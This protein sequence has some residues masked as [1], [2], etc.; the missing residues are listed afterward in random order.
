ME[1][2][3]KMP[4]RGIKFSGLAKWIRVM[5][6]TTFLLFFAV[7]QILA[8][9][10]YSQTKL[11][12]IN[13][14]NATV[15]DIL[16]EIEENSEFY[17]LYSNK[18]INADRKLSVSVEE[19]KMEEVL[20]LIF[21]GEDVAYSIMDRQVIIYPE[22]MLPET[23]IFYQQQ[24]KR[25]S[26]TVTS[27][28]GQP[29]PG[30]TI[31]IEGTTQ[32]TVTNSEGEYLLTNVPED[33][34]LVFSFVGMK[35]QK[36]AVRNQTNIN[37]TLEED[38]IGIEEVVAIGYGT[39]RKRDLTGSVQRADIESFVEQP[40]LSIMQSLHGSVP[41]LNVG[42][43]NQAGQ[44]PVISI[45]GLTTLSGE[46]APLIVLDGVIFRGNI[47]DINPNDIK[48][49]DVLKDASSTAVYGS[50][51]ANGVIIITTS[52]AGGK[53]GKPV[54][55]LSSKYSFQRPYKAFEY[56]DTDYF[57]KK[58]ER[59]DFYSSR[60]EASGYLEPN[61][62]Y[63][64]TSRFNTA[65]E[66]WAYENN[67]IT[68]WYDLVTRDNI[69]TQ[70]HNVS[71]SNTTKVNNYYISLGY[72]DQVGYMLNEDYS[73]INARINVDNNITDWLTVGI[74]S[75]MSQSDYSGAEISPRFRYEHNPYMTVYDE[76]GDY[77]TAP[78][79]Q[80]INP[81]LTA[82]AD[83]LDKRLNISGNIYTEIDI[84]FVKGLSYRVNFNN[85][86]ILRSNYGFADY[87]S[88]L[89]GSGSKSES[90]NYDWTSD[91][92]IT[93]K[94]T[95]NDV[96]DINVTLLYG[97]EKRSYTT[98]Y[99]GAED[100]IN[101][102]LGYN[103][104]QAGNADLYNVSSGAWEENSLYQ[105]ARLFYGY[106][107]KYLLTGTI[108]RDGFS[109]FSKNNKIGIFPSAAFAWVVSEEP[110]ID[111]NIAW[112]DN[113]KMRVSYGANGNRTIARYQTLA[114]VSGGYN[115]VTADE[116]PVYT[117]SVNSLAS[118]NLNWETTTGINLGLDF[119]VLKGH[120]FGTI[121]YYNNNTTNLLYNVDIP[122]I[123][124]YSKFPDNLGKLHNHG[125]DINISSVN[126]KRDGFT[127]ISTVTFARNR[128]EL[129]ELLGF[130]NDGDDKEDDLISEGLFIGEPLS[131]IYTYKLI[132]GEFWGATDER[133]PGFGAGSYKIYDLNED[134]EYTPQDR[135]IIGYRDP[136]YRFSINNELNYNNWTLRIFINSIQGGKNYYYGLDGLSSW[137]T[138]ESI[139]RR[140]VPKEVNFWYPGNPDPVYHRIYMEGGKYG[141]R[142]V[143]R[144]FVRLQD[145]SLSYNLP[146]DMLTNLNIENVK[147]YVSG[148]NLV[149]LTNWPGWDPETGEDISRDGRPV[150]SSFT[151]GLNVEF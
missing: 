101:K 16:Y 32:G 115:Y 75:F 85:I 56:P 53:D 92:I 139:F 97:I 34:T 91:N 80:L 42:Q 67:I 71:I 104:L 9:D 6:V 17:F 37:I 2:K 39:M 59:A 12:T 8:V 89:R 102:V 109:G 146:K 46:T 111:N 96:H 7:V 79:G 83:N 98:T 43:V 70:S 127:W 19:K 31:V 38:V 151:F 54:I 27:Q 13:M 114:R 77:V 61:P 105:M 69:H 138:S 90:K 10:S 120:L 110:F 60:T 20:K 74:Q 22:G 66:D 76:N 23:H 141:D 49:V 33:A 4:N 128:N 137:G 64:F 119:G 132:P 88:N 72:S 18:L 117:Q 94:R 93:Y 150:M 118:P 112:L 29:L 134:G 121:D 55:S 135:E 107:G 50:Q 57:K 65:Y 143:Q 113:L 36:I 78:G 62:N 103:R 47:I 106:K 123:S 142:W 11:L 45:R 1:F 41:G 148:K 5:K 52:K 126:I 133:P 129:K 48:S 14:K 87:G 124:R 140:N 84:P 116:S 131:A 81:F 24:T 44:E 21:K 136:S 145:V 25:V 35:T 95:F 86:Y 40:N 28:D 122:S 99:A 149:T 68:D 125:I 130:D 147:V 144:N 82:E 58:T 100:F 63:D 30:V 108:R 15:R 51:A 26:G 3:R 73:R